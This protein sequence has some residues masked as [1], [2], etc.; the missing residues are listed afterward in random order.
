M[1]LSEFK[2]RLIYRA[3]SKTTRAVNTDKPYLEIQN[4]K[5]RTVII[6]NSLNSQGLL[7][8]PISS[9]MI[10]LTMSLSDYTGFDL[11]EAFFLRLLKLIILFF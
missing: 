3:S 1:N 2:A 9:S 6:C 8:N 10:L 5:D 7:L 11:L 4:K